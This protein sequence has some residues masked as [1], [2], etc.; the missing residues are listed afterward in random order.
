MRSRLLVLLIGL[1]LGIATAASAQ[2]F[3]TMVVPASGGQTSATPAALLA[4]MMF[5]D[6]DG[7]GKVRQTELAERMS[8]IVARGDTNGDEALDADEIGALARRP[9]PKLMSVAGQF[10]GGYGFAD[11]VGLT[12]SRTRIDDAI[13]DLRLPAGTRERAAARA[14]TFVDTL[15]AS[16]AADLL[17]VLEPMLT[18]EQL[19]QVSKA[20]AAQIEQRSGGMGASAMPLPL[21]FRKSAGFRVDQ[22]PFTTAQRQ[23]A[24]AALARYDARIALDD[25]A[26]QDLANQMKGILGEEDRD[27]LRAALG[28]RPVVSAANMRVSVGS[29]IVIPGAV[30]P[31]AVG[32]PQVHK[33]LLVQK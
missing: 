31:G 20:L 24:Q 12:S 33:L 25:A 4:R 23:E 16:A 22:F 17:R 5:F 3:R 10:S 19:T 27:N 15:E 6:R 26:R 14:K 32:M 11:E 18:H 8:G 2:S 28:R 13:A 21:M 9:A 29:Q 30:A 7:D 1:S